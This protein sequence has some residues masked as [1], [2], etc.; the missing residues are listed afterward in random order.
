MFAH[1][2]DTEDLIEIWGQFI[3][4]YNQDLKECKHCSNPDEEKTY[5][6]AL[7]AEYENLVSMLKE[8]YSD[9][10]ELQAIIE[11]D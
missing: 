10:S 9:V 3:D 2:I 7:N 4:Q 5:R 11:C 1:H 6:D 8:K